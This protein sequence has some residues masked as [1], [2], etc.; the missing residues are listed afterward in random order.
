LIST[1]VAYDSVDNAVSILTN[2]LDL[3]F[4]PLSSLGI[5]FLNSFLKLTS[6]P[7]PRATLTWGVNGY[8][9]TM[10]AAG[11][12]NNNND[13]GTTTMMTPVRRQ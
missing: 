5:Y 7:L 8:S 2:L 11:R 3:L 10:A 13:T 1:S 4:C 6:V 12:D 9:S